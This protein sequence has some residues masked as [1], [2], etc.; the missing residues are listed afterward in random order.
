M[1]RI[2]VTGTP[3][4]RIEITE[5]TQRR[6]EPEEFAKALGA[7]PLGEPHSPT[8]DPITLA[9]LGADIIAKGRPQNS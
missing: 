4:K 7:E 2:E 8:L 1:N 6:I 5:K 9:H 3:A